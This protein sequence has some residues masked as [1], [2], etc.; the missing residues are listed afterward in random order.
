[1]CG[2]GILVVICSGRPKKSAIQISQEVGASNYVIS[3]NGAAGYDYKKEEFLFSNKMKK[4]DCIKIYEMA[5]ENDVKFI[6]NT[7]QTRVVTKIDDNFSDTLL[8]EPIEQ[9]LEKT[10]VMQ[11]ILQDKDF[12]KIRE[13]KNKITYMEGIEIK[14]QSKS[15]T[16]PVVKPTDITYCDVADELTSKGYGLEQ[17][18]KK[19]NIDTKDAISIGDDYN[20]VTMFNVTGYSVAMGNANEEVKACA[21]EVTETNNEDGVAVF[22]EKLVRNKGELK[23]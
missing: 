13:L 7:K 4:E 2:L 17:F 11:C 5:K 8:S 19:L 18:C 15:L 21:K 1:M 6:M 3:S 23:C 22:L 10:E 20:D 9:F 14:N 16:N 12:E